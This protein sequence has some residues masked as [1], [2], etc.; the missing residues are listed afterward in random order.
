MMNS[1]SFGD[2]RAG[3]PR[4]VAEGYT[5]FIPAP[6]PTDLTYP[7]PL[8]R[9]LSEA[10]AALSE[11]SGLGRYLP[12]PNLLIEPYMRR[13]AVASSRIEGTR[14]DLSD[15]LLDEL[16]PDHTP[17]NSDVGEVRNYVRAMR[18][19]ISKLDELPLT[20]RLVRELHAVLMQGV[21]GEH[22]TPGEFRRSQNWIGP[23]GSTLTT[24]S[25]IPPPVEE[26][27]GCI[28][29]WERFVNERGR[30]P[31]LIQCALMHEN[32]EAI[33]PFIDG[34]GRVGRLLITLFLMERGRLSTPLLYLSSYIEREPNRQT[35][36]ELLQRIRTH[37]DWGA[38]LEYFLTAVRETASSARRQGDALLALRDR[39]RAGLQNKHRAAALL[40]KLFINPYVTAPRAADLLGVT[41]PTALRS[42]QELVKAGILAQREGKSRA[43]QWEAAPI[44]RVI[45]EEG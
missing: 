21:R 7:P 16:D 35:Y 11:L 20:G 39:Y 2:V 26:M 12:N 17:A 31:D 4:R 40:D 23:P 33:H 28:A 25:Y 15:L 5:A 18:L 36:Y 32:F 42:I 38:W 14:A 24:A 45:S 13:E 9:L 27:K 37:G 29:A 3:R 44:L 6:P 34:N 19:G 43:R 22:A 1:A 41:P 10:D 30:M 8:V